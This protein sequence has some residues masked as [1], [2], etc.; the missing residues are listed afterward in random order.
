VVDLLGPLRAAARDAAAR[1][2]GGLIFWRDDTHWNAAGIATAA[3]AI[4]TAA[5]AAATP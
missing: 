3:R 5:Q 4:A 1:R 2:G